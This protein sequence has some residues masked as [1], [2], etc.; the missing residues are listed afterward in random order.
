MT[1][2]LIAYTLYGA[3]YIAYATFI[4]AYLPSLSLT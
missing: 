4:I 3:G 1:L 2:V